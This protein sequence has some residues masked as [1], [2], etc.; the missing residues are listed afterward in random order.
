MKFIPSL[1]IHTSHWV[2]SVRIASL[3]GF[4]N[5]KWQSGLSPSELETECHSYSSGP[6]GKVEEESRDSLA[7]NEFTL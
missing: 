5:G 6:L 4:S 1:L 7:E 3:K 2:F